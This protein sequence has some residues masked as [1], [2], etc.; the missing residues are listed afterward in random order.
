MQGSRASYRLESIYILAGEVQ[1]AVMDFL[2][3]TKVGKLSAPRSR[4]QN[5]LC[6]CLSLSLPSCLAFVFVIDFGFILPNYN[7]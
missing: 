3:A 6:L 1:L 2:V 7:G 4:V 5:E